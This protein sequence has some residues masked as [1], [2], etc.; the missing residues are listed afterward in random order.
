MTSLKS[1]FLDEILLHYRLQTWARVY[2]CRTAFTY[3]QCLRNKGENPR[4][5]LEE[6]VDIFNEFSQIEKRTADNITES[7]ALGLVTFD[8]L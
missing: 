4:L 3:A 7:D 2:I 8:Y 5:L 6:A 1:A